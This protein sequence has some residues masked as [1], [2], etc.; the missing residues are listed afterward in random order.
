MKFSNKIPRRKGDNLDLLLS[1]VEKQEFS[2]FI[3]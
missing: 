2:I 1:F 3:A